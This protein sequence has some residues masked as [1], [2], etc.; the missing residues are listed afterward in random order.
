MVS[1]LVSS[2]GFLALVIGILMGFGPDGMRWLWL[3][4]GIGAAA[5]LF[6]IAGQVKGKNE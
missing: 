6:W 3:A 2:A 1:K 4:G 5:L